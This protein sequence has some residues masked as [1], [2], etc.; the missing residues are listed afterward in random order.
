MAG[1][2]KDLIGQTFTR[3]KVME[4]V[5][6]PE[7]VTHKNRAYWLCLC[8]CGNELTLRS[9]ILTTG[10]TTSCGCLRNQKLSSVNFVDLTGKRFGFL[11]VESRTERPVNVSNQ[12]AY[13]ACL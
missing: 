1:V 4:R 11:T 5:E 13:W 3:L 6:P 2:A 7:G 10:N 8:M 9:D 12:S